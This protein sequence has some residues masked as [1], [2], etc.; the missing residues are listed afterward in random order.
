LAPI[1][2]LWNGVVTLA[3]PICGQLLS[4][5]VVQAVTLAADTTV[6]RRTSDGGSVNDMFLVPEPVAPAVAVTVTPTPVSDASRVAD[7]AIVGAYASVEHPVGV[8]DVLA[9]TGVVLSYVVTVALLVS[10][11][12]DVG[13]RVN[14]WPSTVPLIVSLIST[15]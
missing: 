10:A 14:A 9:V 4:A 3:V 13:L 1:D 15:I 11:A 2:A 7:A 8:N 6:E 12:H 5:F